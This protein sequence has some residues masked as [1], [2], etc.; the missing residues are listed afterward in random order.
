MVAALDVLPD[1]VDSGVWA[2]VRI[3]GGD[4]V[5]T[6][7]GLAVKLR[8]G[9]YVH[10]IGNV[11]DNS[12]VWSQRLQQAGYPPPPTWIPGVHGTWIGQVA[13]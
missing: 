2:T 10:P 3:E 6:V 7:L 13:E 12:I 9:Q 1:D 4:H 11:T 5:L 8:N